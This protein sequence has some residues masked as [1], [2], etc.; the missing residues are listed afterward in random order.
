M[1]K[2]ISIASGKGGVG[3]SFC[4][5]SLAL[6]LSAAGYRTLLVDADLGGANL[7]NF[8]GLKVPGIGLYNF[9]RERSELK[10]V[11]VVSTCKTAVACDNNIAALFAL[12]LF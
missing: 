8:V 6:S 11:I 12:T 3:K 7:H 10:D 2:L 4:S 5:S 9:I 1:S